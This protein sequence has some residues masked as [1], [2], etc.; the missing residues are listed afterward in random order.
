[1]PRACPSP[2]LPRSHLRV[3]HW[4]LLVVAAQHVHA[5]LLASSSVQRCIRNGS[6]AA[7]AVDPTCSQKLV[8]TLSVNSNQASDMCARH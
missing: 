1:M 5:A 6:S 8:V 3:V 2:A 4:V 7:T